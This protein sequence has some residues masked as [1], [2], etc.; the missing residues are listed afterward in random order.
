M[1]VYLVREPRDTEKFDLF[2]QYKDASDMHESYGQEALPIE[3][4][5]VI[6]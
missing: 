2:I 3:E 4:H 6:E 1:K 5:E